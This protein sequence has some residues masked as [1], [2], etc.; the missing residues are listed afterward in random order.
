MS[1]INLHFKISKFLCRK[2]SFHGGVDAQDQ[3]FQVY[4]PN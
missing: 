3:I 4:T 1:N 2:V